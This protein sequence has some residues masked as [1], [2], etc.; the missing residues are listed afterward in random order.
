MSDSR[1]MAAAK[2]RIN[3]ASSASRIAHNSRKGRSSKWIRPEKRLA[4]YLRDSFQCQYCGRDLHNAPAWDVT[5]D[6]LVPQ[7]KAVDG[8]LPRSG[9]SIHHESNIV[10]A[11]LSCN[12]KRQENSWRKYATPGAVERISRNRRRTLNMSLSVRIFS[13]EAT[14]AEYLRTEEGC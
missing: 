9:K 14:V 10:T 6:H 11:C 4:V 5:L 8:K 1:S 3:A 7:C 13:G 2:R 12:S